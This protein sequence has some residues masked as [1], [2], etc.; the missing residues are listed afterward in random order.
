MSEELAVYC[1]MGAA[2]FRDAAIR[3]AKERRWNAL[4]RHAQIMLIRA[5]GTNR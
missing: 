5:W 2:G 4:N 1:A 3:F